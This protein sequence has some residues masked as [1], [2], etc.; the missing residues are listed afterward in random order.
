M[1]KLKLPHQD[2]CWQHNIILLDRFYNCPTKIFSST[3]NTIF[4]FSLMLNIHFIKNELTSEK[5]I[6]NDNVILLKELPLNFLAYFI[7]NSELNLSFHSGPIVHISPAFDR[8]IIDL[9]P[10]SKN[11][12]L[13]RWIPSVS[14]YRRI[15][16]ED[17]NDKIIENI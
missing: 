2:H 16:F 14:N 5:T 10:K 3:H 1:S 17:L 11:N 7:K 4:V 6:G 15:N 13:D 9:I 8:K 12:E